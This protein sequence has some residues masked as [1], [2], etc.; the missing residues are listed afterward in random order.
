MEETKERLRQLKLKRMQ[1]QQILAEAMVKD[2]KSLEVGRAL[3]LIRF[4]SKGKWH[5]I[6]ESWFVF[7]EE[8]LRDEDTAM[9]KWL[10]E[11]K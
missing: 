5:E 1:R 8:L 10:R 6:H 7:M 2:I 11:T 4:F 9:Q 3:T